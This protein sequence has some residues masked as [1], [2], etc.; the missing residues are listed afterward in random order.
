[1]GQYYKTIILSDSVPEEGKQET[2]RLALSAL[3]YHNGLKLTEHSW[4]GN[5]FVSVIEW[6]ISP[7]GMFYKSRLVWAGDYADSEPIERQNLYHIAE[8]Y[9]KQNTYPVIM[10]PKDFKAETYR[11][12]INHTKR[13]Y[14]DK[15]RAKND[16]LAFTVSGIE[17]V[18]HP[19][20][21]LVAEGNGR[22]GGD[23][24]GDNDNLCGI[25]T[26]DIIS[27]ETSVP[28]EFTE[29]VCGFRE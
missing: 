10:P 21:L 26:R 15:E 22:G 20:P 9:Q 3:S 23:Y 6:L 4:L 11:Y 25:W 27:V 1:M 28:T 24:C 2:V 29:R 8:P 19:L 5:S 14:V 7:V 12:I 13:E 17:Y 16:G 18:V